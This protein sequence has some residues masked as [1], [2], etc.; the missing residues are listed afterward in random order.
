MTWR[1]R[2]RSVAFQ[3]GVSSSACQ[4]RTGRPGTSAMR[5]LARMKALRFS[6]EGWAPLIAAI[7]FPHH[8]LDRIGGVVGGVGIACGDDE[9]LDA[10]GGFV[11]AHGV[12]DVVEAPGFCDLDIRGDAPDE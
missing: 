4:R 6:S 10:G 2:S 1:A 5:V 11:P 9:A 3:I 12:E 8:H 7:L